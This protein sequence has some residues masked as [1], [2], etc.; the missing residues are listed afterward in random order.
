M[1]NK[2]VVAMSG[3]VDSAVAAL[4]LKEQGYEVVGITCQIWLD[5]ICNVKSSKSCCGHEAV[6][7]A[8][9]TAARIGIK[10][11]VFNYREL[12][13]EKVINKFCNEYLEGIT[14]NPC[15]DCNLYIRSVD[16]LDKVLGMG[17]DYLATGHYIIRDF[18][19]KKQ[20][21]ILKK[22]LDPSKDQSYFLYQLDQEKLKH[23]LFPLGE[24]RKK[25]VREIAESFGLKIASKEESQDICF[26]TDGSYDKFIEDYKKVQGNNT[27]IY[28]VD[29]SYLG[30]GK[31][32]YAY[33]IGQRK[34]LGIAYVRPLYVVD[35]DGKKNRIIVGDKEDTVAKGLIAL[36]NFFISKASPKE[37]DLVYVKVRYRSQPTLARFFKEAKGFRLEFLETTTAVTKG[38]S[39]V[40]Y[41]QEEPDLLLGGGRITEV[42]K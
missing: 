3:G 31:P 28:H 11:Y 10:H 9:E 14:P 38:Q 22:G 34:G 27:A 41:S 24:L 40:I 30:E 15:M 35:I 21:Y 18:D 20:E 8:R 25:E 6:D 12:F 16:L 39:A 7:D 42:L 17:F 1:G 13:E 19:E 2:V 26:I 29:G 5:D 37:G 33:T 36:D 32:I 23:L 4:L